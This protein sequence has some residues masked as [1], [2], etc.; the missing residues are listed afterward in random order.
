MELLIVVGLVAA[1]VLLD[2]LAVS[3]GEDSRINRTQPE[4]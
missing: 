2:V 1:L 3:F 4:I